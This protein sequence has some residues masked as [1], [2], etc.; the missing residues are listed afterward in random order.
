M[1]IA[2]PTNDREIIAVRSGRAKEFA[3]FD[4]M[5]DLSNHKFIENPHKHDDHN[6]EEGQGHNHSHADMI[7]MFKSNNVELIIVNVIGKHFLKDLKDAG[8]KI[9]KTKVENLEEI[10]VL[11]KEDSSKFAE[12]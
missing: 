9:Y 11:F 3:F 12:V 6:H 4:L 7:D 8:L 2:I 10:F 5:E 1:I